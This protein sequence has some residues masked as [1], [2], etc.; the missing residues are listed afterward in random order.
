MSIYDSRS[1]VCTWNGPPSFLAP[2]APQTCFQSAYIPNPG[3]PNNAFNQETLG[4]GG[5]NTPNGL[6]CTKNVNTIGGCR[7]NSECGADSVCN[8]GRC[9]PQ[10]STSDVQNLKGF[11]AGSSALYYNGNPK[12]ISKIPWPNVEQMYKS[13]GILDTFNTQIKPLAYGNT[14]FVVE[15]QGQTFIACPL[16]LVNLNQQPQCSTCLKSIFPC[17]KFSDMAEYSNK[18]KGAQET[19]QSQKQVFLFNVQDLNGVTIP[20]MIKT[21]PVSV[22][23]ASAALQKC[24]I[25]CGNI[26][27]DTPLT[28]NNSPMFI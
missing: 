2:F 4:C 19:C 5:G 14:M 25:Q 8:N 6:T 7:Y 28:R 17:D 12:V 23:I 16:N 13:A 9:Y 10:Y 21:D 3:V 20:I 26:Y 11:M 15:H 22:E 1:G 27:M 24:V 18:A